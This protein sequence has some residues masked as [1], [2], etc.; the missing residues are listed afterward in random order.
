MPAAPGQPSPNQSGMQPCAS[1]QIFA[2]VG[3][4]V[5][6]AADVMPRVNE[7]A[8][9]HLKEIPP[10]QLDLVRVVWAKKLLEEMVK[11]KLIYLDAHREIP[12][13]A[14]PNVEK[15]VDEIFEKEEVPKIMKRLKATSKAEMENRLRATGTTLERERQAH[16][17]SFLARQWQQEKV[18]I[19]EEISHQETIDYYHDHSKEFEHPARARWEELMTR[20]SGYPSKAAAS[21]ALAQMGN[22]V[23][24]GASFAEVAKSRSDGL[25]AS[26]GGVHDWTNQ[27]SLVDAEMDQALFGLPVGTLSKIIEDKQG[28]HIIRVIERKEIG[29]T[30]FIE[31]QVKIRAKIKE[32]RTKKE[33]SAYIER[34][35]EQTPIWIASDLSAG[36][37][38]LANF[39]EPSPDPSAVKPAAEPGPRTS[40]APGSAP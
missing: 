34:L 39:G 25:T 6:L 24:N 18:K 26:K 13:E 40:E 8:A 28:F 17:E 38:P 14:M 33:T 7:L 31:A 35:R 1:S 20:V 15:R 9:A 5:I 11:M 37:I 30:P 12:K 4:D 16:L 2:R 36:L 19:N 32:Q 29:R 23:I 27:G 10:E 21:D 22:A 3:S